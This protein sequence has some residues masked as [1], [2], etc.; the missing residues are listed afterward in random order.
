MSFRAAIQAARLTA[1]P[2]V[3]WVYDEEIDEPNGAPQSIDD[4]F[5]T[6]TA[7]FGRAI[8]SG[9]KDPAFREV[10]VTFAG[11]PFASLFYTVSINGVEATGFT[12]VSGLSQAVSRIVN[13]INSNFGSIVTALQTAP[14]GTPSG[15]GTA[16][17]VRGVTDADFSFGI[18]VSQLF[19]T[20]QITAD[21]ASVDAMVWALPGGVPSTAP[22]EWAVIDRIEAGLVPE[23]RS[24]DLR[25]V[26]RVYIEAKRLALVP[27]DDPDINLRARLRGGAMR[28]SDLQ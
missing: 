16:L 3:R 15:F 1:G 6:R 2:R 13:T 14:D 20:R 19:I 21:P 9:R 25:S 28:R 12:N 18:D 23:M 5:D 10:F 7:V 26:R 17:R 8:V 4:G 24:L 11:F 27:G 22:D